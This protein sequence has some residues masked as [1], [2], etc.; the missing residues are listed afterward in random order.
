MKA[1]TISPKP[2]LSAG[3]KT[4]WLL[5]IFGAAMV[6]VPVCFDQQLEGWNGGQY[7][8][9]LTGLLVA[10]TA[11]FSTFLFRRHRKIGDPLPNERH[12]RD[13]SEIMLTVRQLARS[14]IDMF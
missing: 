4:C 3:E 14:E 5:T 10:V 2:G 9:G 8:L 12:K 13:V 7:A 11:F 1:A 6:A